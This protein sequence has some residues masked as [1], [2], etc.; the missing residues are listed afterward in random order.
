[1]SPTEEYQRT[2]FDK[3]GPEAAHFWKAASYLL[4]PTLGGAAIGAAYFAHE[5][6]SNVGVVAGTFVGALLGGAGAGLLIA[7]MSQGASRMFGEFIQPNHSPY[8][9]Q[10]SYEDALLM[11]GDVEGALASY[12]KIIAASPNDPQPRLRAAELCTKSKMREQAEAHYRAVQRLPRLAAKDDIYATNRLVDLYLAWP[13]RETKCL[14]ELRRLIDTYPESDV[15][16]HARAGLVNLKSQLG[17][18]E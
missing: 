1:V 9:R 6:F 18:A 2:L 15:A 4:V 12:D 7:S 11:R 14:R 8:E 16:E 3:H 13:G 5:G 17:V 10:Y